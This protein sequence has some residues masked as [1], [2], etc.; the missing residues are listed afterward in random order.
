M[1]PEMTICLKQS[2]SFRARRLGHA[3][4]LKLAIILDDLTKEGIIRESV[5]SYASLIVLIRK[6]DGNLRLCINYREINKISIKDNP[7]PLTDDHLD[8]LKGKRIFNHLDLQ[9]GFH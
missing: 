3:D 1:V 8:R 9:N 6:K 2:I 5:S 7:M 4:K